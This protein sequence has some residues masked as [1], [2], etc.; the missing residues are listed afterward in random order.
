MLTKNQIVGEESRYLKKSHLR[1]RRRR[2]EN[3]KRKKFM[4]R[5]N[6]RTKMQGKGAERRERKEE[7]EVGKEDIEAEKD[8]DIMVVI[9]EG[10]VAVTG[11]A[12]QLVG[13][14]EGEE[15]KETGEKVTTAQGKA[16]TQ[17]SL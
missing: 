17:L 15:E 5:V 4:W 7:A 9:E 12:E 13:E 16:I 2:L 14:V 8:D 11:G 6:Q 1:R 10:E 3:V